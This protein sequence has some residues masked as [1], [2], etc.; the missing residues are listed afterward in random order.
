MEHREEFVKMVMS[1]IDVWMAHADL[2]QVL[3]R[4]RVTHAG[5][6]GVRGG[7]GDVLNRTVPKS[8]L[9]FQKFV[10]STEIRGRGR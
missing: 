3:S 9:L 1:Q 4:D 5:V 7:D 2:E 8:L 10:A 6:C